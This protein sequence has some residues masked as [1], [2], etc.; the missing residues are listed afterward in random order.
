MIPITN[1]DTPVA[2]YIWRF[3]GV[4]DI[5]RTCEEF[6]EYANDSI[7]SSFSHST[8]PYS[9]CA[10]IAIDVD[11]LIGNSMIVWVFV[12]HFPI[13]DKVSVSSDCPWGQ[14]PIF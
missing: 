7:C 12:Y 10:S 6:P 5:L 9:H 2:Q 3:L 1:D 8:I 14:Y 13:L 4:A 11:L